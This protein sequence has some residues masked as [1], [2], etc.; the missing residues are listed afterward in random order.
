MFFM[1]KLSRVFICCFIVFSM[2]VFAAPVEVCD[3][4]EIETKLEQL[5]LDPEIT[6]NNQF[7]LGIEEKYGQEM[8]ESISVVHP[9]MKSA[10]DDMIDV[11]T[12]YWLESYIWSHKAPNTRYLPVFG[13]LRNESV[14]NEY[15]KVAFT[16]LYN[17]SKKSMFIFFKKQD[18]KLFKKD[19]DSNLTKFIMSYYPHTTESELKTKIEAFKFSYLKDGNFEIG[20]HN[21]ETEKPV[22]VIVG[23]G[24][25]DGNSILIGDEDLKIDVFVSKLKESGLKNQATIKLNSCYSGCSKIE[26]DY[27]LEEIK[28]MFK[29][30]I[31]IS[32][33]GSVYG[34]LMDRFSSHLFKEIPSFNGVVQGYIG[35]LFQIPQQNVLKKNGQIMKRGNASEIVGNNG[36]IKLKKEEVRVSMTRKD[37]YK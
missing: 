7:L 34:S 13:N 30:G 9:Y 37:F 18:Y 14:I 12:I 1:N 25:V 8:V 16:E 19:L 28:Y 24:D 21:M 10:P 32:A 15:I 22:V 29:N 26:I 2:S 4:K 36:A 6:T 20:F 23:H 33:I 27:S 11:A 5:H 17:K 31:L 35:N 3:R